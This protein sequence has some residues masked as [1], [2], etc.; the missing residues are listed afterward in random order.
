MFVGSVLIQSF[1]DFT[2]GKR[3]YAYE[4]YY[5]VL[6]LLVS[7][8]IEVL[9]THHFN[10]QAQKVGMLIRCTLIPSLYKKRL[11]LS[12]SA[13]QDHGVGTI[14]NYMVVDT[15]QL[16]DMMLQLHA[17]WMMPLQVVLALFCFTIV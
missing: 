7:K 8:F 1:V 9:T 17:V 6:I 2:S 3:S 16:S 13:R 10:F 4:G 14:V 11:K 15:Q 5:L 12:F